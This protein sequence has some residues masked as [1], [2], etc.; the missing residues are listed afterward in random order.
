MAKEQ[1]GLIKEVLA[2]SLLF[3]SSTPISTLA[4]FE[5]QEACLRLSARTRLSIWVV[6]SGAACLGL[7][8][9]F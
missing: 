8:V 1:P 6:A 4:V 2:V 9:P 5:Q 7:S 3:E